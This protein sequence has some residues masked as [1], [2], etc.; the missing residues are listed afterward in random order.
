MSASHYHAKDIGG[1]IYRNLHPDIIACTDDRLRKQSLPVGIG[2]KFDAL[3]VWNKLEST[4]ESVK[5]WHNFRQCVGISA[6]QIGIALRQSI[7]WTPQLGYLH[8]ANPEILEYTAE[9]RT[10]YETCLTSFELRGRVSRPD[11]ILLRF[12]QRDFSAKE[13][14]FTGWA[15]RM[16]QHEIDHMNGILFTDRMQVGEKTIS[17]ED[18]LILRAAG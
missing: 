4:I 1:H 5:E 13:Q 16:I 2:N 6:I 10:E 12:L 18:Y 17:H 9:I 3:G 14:F 11:G 7:V 8:I 15:A